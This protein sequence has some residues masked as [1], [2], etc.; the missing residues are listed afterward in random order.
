MT[1]LVDHYSDGQPH[2]ME[3]SEAIWR[4]LRAMAERY[5]SDI[6]LSDG[7]AKRGGEEPLERLV[8]LRKGCPGEVVIEIMKGRTETCNSLELHKEVQPLHQDD[9]LFIERWG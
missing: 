5:P 6:I 3:V 1:Y 4:V 8:L 2:L 9:S 7:L